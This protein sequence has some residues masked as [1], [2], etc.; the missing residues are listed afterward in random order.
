VC[1]I[2]AW[3]S[4][5]PEPSRKP[6]EC[7]PDRGARWLPE[8]VPR[9]A[10][11]YD[12]LGRGLYRQSDLANGGLYLGAFLG[13]DLGV[14]APGSP[15]W[16]SSARFEDAAR[17]ALVAGSKSGREAAATASDVL[18]Y[19]TAGA[20]L[21]LDA[22]AGSWLRHGDCAA[23]LE[24]FG[25]AAEAITLTLLVT[26][27]TKLLAARERPFQRECLLDPGYDDDCFAEDSRKSFFS[28]HASVAAAG[29]GLLCRS[30]YRREAPVWGRLGS[31]RNPIP[32][33][34]GV[35][36]AVA[37]GLLRTGADKHWLGDVLAG[38]ALG[39]AIGLFDLPGPFDLLHF[40]YEHAGRN[41]HG[42]LL[43]TL[44]AGPVGARLHL[45][46]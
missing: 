27:A 36:A 9:G 37:T 44:G 29:A 28:G 14:E 31:I 45:R 11:G 39:A 1:A 8:G 30:T 15:R 13:L 24:I 16:A 3:G 26:E 10:G 33:A 46:F 7:A 20:P 19:L 2:P 32:C 34:L 41:S 21:W 22:G 6:W 43:P 18:L 42:M 5:A 38:W 4:G 25:E 40:R 23:A 17:D 12:G 35:G